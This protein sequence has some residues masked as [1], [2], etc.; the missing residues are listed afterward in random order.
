[1]PQLFVQTMLCNPAPIK[2][3]SLRTPGG[4][5]V[6]VPPYIYRQSHACSKVQ[7]GRPKPLELG[8]TARP[9]LMQQILGAHLLGQVVIAGSHFHSPCHPWSCMS[10][11]ECRACVQL[12]GRLYLV[13][14]ARG[15]GIWHNEV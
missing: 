3:L 7:R 9:A 13:S 6:K 12:L 11:W 8:S 5:G 10:S 15:R 14:T 4:S 2:W 1:M